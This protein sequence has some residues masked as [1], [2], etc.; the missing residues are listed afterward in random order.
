MRRGIPRRV[1][2]ATALVATLA[3]AATA[4]GDDGDSGDDKA[5][6]PVTITWWDTSNATNEAPTYKALIEEFQTANPNIK[7]K[8]VN[9][10]FDQAQDKFQTAAG[11]KGAPDVLRAEVGWTPGFAK[12]QFLAPL[13][14]TAALD[15]QDDITPS[16]LKQAQYEGKTYGAP[17]VTDTLGLMWNKE[18][19]KKAGHDAPPTTWD[20]LKQV[21][22]DVKSKAGVDGFWLNNA[23]YYELPFLYGEGTDM[24]DAA[25]KKITIN[26][27]EAVKGVDV[28]KDI[29]ASDGVAK[30]DVT[31]DAYA[32]MMDAFNNGKV[33]MIVQ[34]PW[35]LT[36]V[37][38]GAAFADKA[39]LGVANVPAGSSGKSG[40]PTGGHNLSVYA[41]SSKEKQEAAFKFVG[42][43][44]SGET[45]AKIAV[46]NG[47]LP[48]R[49]S[50]YTAEVTAT[51]GVADFQKVLAE[52][53]QPRP[54]L[55]EYSSLLGDDFGQNLTKILQ[56]K[57]ST[58]DGLNT[59]AEKFKKLVP[60]FS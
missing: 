17:I 13:D 39:N 28:S 8:Y 41:G 34:G 49:T 21:A 29:L 20:E 45:Q 54:E 6:G 26:S 43:M 37:F 12:S 44:T 22:K 31:A 42:F 7:V 40:A 3:L 24:V 10:P 30:L 16:L 23:T 51:P 15:K 14:G 2:T 60:D 36:N 5:S 9:V 27:P 52:S 18:L 58:Q 25:G 57:T 4:C 19:L 53:A 46:K 59:I 32:H 33:A 56:G 47:T 55:A 38:K 1:V 35:E 48:T 11:S 50:A